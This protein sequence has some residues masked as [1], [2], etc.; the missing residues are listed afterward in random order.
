V[1]YHVDVN[2]YRVKKQRVVD[3]R[4]YPITAYFYKT[5]C[6]STNKMVYL[7]RDGGVS[8]ATM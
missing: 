5:L 4:R 6:T 3:N 8:E 1:D 2:A 7:Q